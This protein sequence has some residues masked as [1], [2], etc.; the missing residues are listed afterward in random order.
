MLIISGKIGT[1]LAEEVKGV[2]NTIEVVED[3]KVAV[4]ILVEVEFTER[5]ARSAIRLKIN[6]KKRNV[7]FFTF[8]FSNNSIAY[9]SLNIKKLGKI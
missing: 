4:D 8:K 1:N 7:N 9:N 5:Q 3:I 6:I 2:I